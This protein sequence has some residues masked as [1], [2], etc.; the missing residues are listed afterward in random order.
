MIFFI[1]TQTLE[2]RASPT[3]KKCNNYFDGFPKMLIL[4]FAGKLKIFGPESGSYCQ[5]LSLSVY[6][7]SF[8][9]KRKTCFRLYHIVLSEREK[10]YK[11]FMNLM[12]SL[13]LS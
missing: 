5:H 9:E 6:E 8:F 11:P 12:V 10:T 7:I 2:K 3:L 4:R 1:K 13:A